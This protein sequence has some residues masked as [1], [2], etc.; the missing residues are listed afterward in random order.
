MVMHEVTVEPQ[1]RLAGRRLSDIQLPAGCFVVSLRRDR[2]L[3]FPHTST[4]IEPGDTITLFVSPQG[5]AQW[6][7][8][9]QTSPEK[10]ASSS[11]LI[12]ETVAL[13]SIPPL[14]THE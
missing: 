9:L 2:E 4:M 5:E 11:S 12:R 1:M 6:Q 8:F 13:C 3:L 10:E 14:E 7:A